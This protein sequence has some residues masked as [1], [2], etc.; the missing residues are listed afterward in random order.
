[1]IN[2]AVYI[3]LL[4]PLALP[5]PRRP[6]HVATAP[7]VLHPSLRHVPLLHPTDQSLR[8]VYSEQHRMTPNIRKTMHCIT[9]LHL[10]WNSFT[11]R[12]HFGERFCAQYISKLKSKIAIFLITKIPKCRLRE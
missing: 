4:V 9:Y 11:I 7:V 6:L 3:P 1:L 10:K 8:R 12:Q 5:L 2:T